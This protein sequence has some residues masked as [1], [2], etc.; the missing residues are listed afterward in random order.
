MSHHSQKFVV[1]LAL[2]ILST[3]AFAEG[4]KIYEELN[5]PVEVVDCMTHK[6]VEVQSAGGSI[7]NA[8]SR[9]LERF[10]NAAS[11]DAA[12]GDVDTSADENGAPSGGVEFE[13]GYQP[14]V[15]V[16]GADTDFE[17]EFQSFTKIQKDFTSTFTSP[18]QHAASPSASTLESSND[19]SQIAEDELESAWSKTINSENAYFDSIA[20]LAGASGDSQAQNA[21]AHATISAHLAIDVGDIQ[22]E[23][24][25]DTK[26]IVFQGGALDTQKD[27]MN[28]A[29]GRG[30]GEEILARGGS[31]EDVGEAIANAY[32]AGKLWIIRNGKIVP[33]NQ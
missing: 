10:G 23:L 16:L 12:A 11:S 29:A 20:F 33:S 8:S 17:S 5:E 26:E 21:I 28:N 32:K 31:A 24:I 7:G 3:G 19:Y 14:P 22:A 13:S 9:N 2:G 4:P 1:L 27:Q 18:S 30:I 25:G 6:C 15:G